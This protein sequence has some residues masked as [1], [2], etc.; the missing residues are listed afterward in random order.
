MIGPMI[1][2]MLAGVLTKKL[3]KVI[4]VSLLEIAVENTDNKWDDK[5]LKKVKE[6]SNV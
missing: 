1:A 4:I 3:L 5:L 6:S 2:K